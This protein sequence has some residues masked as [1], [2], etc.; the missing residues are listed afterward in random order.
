MSIMKELKH[1]VRDSTTSDE[2]T[3][4]VRKS[5]K[6]LGWDRPGSSSGRTGHSGSYRDVV[7]PDVVEQRIDSSIYIT[8][9]H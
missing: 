6:D 9:N 3:D 5:D 7:K 1:R 2:G 8:Q 4:L